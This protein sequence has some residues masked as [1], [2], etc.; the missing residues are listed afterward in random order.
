MDRTGIGSRK[1]IGLLLALN[2]G[3]FLAG[4][5]FQYGSPAARAPLVFNAEKITLLA[6]PTVTS[7]QVPAAETAVA[8]GVQASPAPAQSETGIAASPRCLSWKSLDAEGLISIEAHLKQIGIA[9]NAYD[10]ELAKKLGW[11]VYLPPVE[12]KEALQAT[13]DEVRRLGVLDYAVV[14]GGSMRNALSLGAFAKLA[15][16]REHALGLSKK[17]IKGVKFGPRPEAGEARL[18]FSESIPIGALAKAESGWPSGLPPTRCVL[19]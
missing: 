7:T 19:P 18:V 12:N 2:L 13:I 10:I 1:L 17:G 9:S 15:Q 3:V 6:V 16:A 4:M 11:W 8:P 5:A 14:R